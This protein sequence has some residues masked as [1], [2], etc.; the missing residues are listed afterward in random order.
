MK[1]NQYLYLLLIFLL[2]GFCG[3]STSS[4]EKAGIRKDYS[5]EKESIII[6]GTEL[7][8]VI[9]G[10]GKPVLVIGSS[11]YYPRTFS[12]ELRNHLRFYFVDMRWFAKNYLPVELIEYNLNTVTS[13]IE[14]V[15][16]YLNLDKIIIVGHSIHGAIAFEYARRFPDRVSN[17]IMIGS[18]NYQSNTQQED[19]VNDIWKTASEERVKVMNENWKKLAA[20]KGLSAAQFEIENYCLMCPKYWYD[21]NYDAHWLWEDMTLNT[22]LLYHIYSSVFN[23]YYMFR[24]ERKVPAPT[25]VAL[26]R[27]DYIDPPTLWYG[28]DDIKDLTI[29]IFDRSGHT[30]QLE[31]PEQFNNEILMWLGLIN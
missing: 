4:S 28:H 12:S 11:V 15:R 9:E 2:T 6:D 29:K 20:M 17:I 21:P 5:S 31:E 1:S 25:F 22:D 30:P 26:G 10:T 19:A 7:N 3:C 23:D 27:Y 24:E 13:D 18:P 16:Q 8:C 14:K